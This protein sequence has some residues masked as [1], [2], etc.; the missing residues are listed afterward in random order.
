M[1]GVYATATAPQGQHLRTGVGEVAG[2]ILG[3]VGSQMGGLAVMGGA[4]L[5]AGIV[6]VPA[7]VVFVAA[8]VG[9]AP[10]GTWAL[11]LSLR[12]GR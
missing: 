3:A 12:Q 8:V 5:L 1:L 2:I 9:Q 10:M 11:G 6:V 7:G 4:G